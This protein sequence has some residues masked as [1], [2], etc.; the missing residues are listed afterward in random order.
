MT[1]TTIC[2]KCDELIVADNYLAPLIYACPHCH[3]QA[4]SLLQLKCNSCNHMLPVSIW[5]QYI[6]D[7]LQAAWKAVWENHQLDD[8][9]WDRA[10]DRDLDTEWFIQANLCCNRHWSACDC[11]Y[12][13]SWEDVISMKDLDLGQQEA[14]LA[15][16]PCED[17]FFFESARCVP[18]R[19]WHAKIEIN[20]NTDR[21]NVIVPQ[22]DGCKNY[23]KDP[24]S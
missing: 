15:D 9:V 1:N 23:R 13:L 21:T 11:E 22:I 12:P 17:C 3:V 18:L 4:V 24:F 16:S 6:D 19:N 7:L 14:Y 10:I 8:D 2:D 20:Q 5:R